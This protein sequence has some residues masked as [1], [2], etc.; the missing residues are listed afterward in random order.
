M[1]AVL[2]ADLEGKGSYCSHCLRKIE[3]DIVYRIENDLYNSGYCSKE[4][5]TKSKS[6]SQNLLFGTDSALPPEL[7]TAEMPGDFTAARR[8]AQTEFA[9]YVKD[10]DKSVPMLVARFIARQARSSSFL[11]V[12]FVILIVRS[13]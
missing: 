9:K 6:L 12:V 5:Q 11:C 7:S 3:D 8:E 2:D 4:C 10:Q 13:Y 1:V